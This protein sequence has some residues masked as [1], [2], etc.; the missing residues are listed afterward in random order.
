MAGAAAAISSLRIALCTAKTG[1]KHLRFRNYKFA[2]V[3]CFASSSSAAS[4]IDNLQTP[5]YL[6]NTKW[7][8]FRKKKVVMRV[9]Y[10]GTDYRGMCVYFS[11]YILS[12]IHIYN[13][14]VVGLQKQL[15]EHSLSSMY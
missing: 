3:C 11:I 10:I 8:P 1:P 14:Y 15:D 13:C 12:L 2:I 7:D 6:P 4:L 9:G 5:Y